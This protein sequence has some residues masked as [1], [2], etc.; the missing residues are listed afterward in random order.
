[1]PLQ[2]AASSKKSNKSK[3]Y[4]FVCPPPAIRS[5]VTHEQ[6][7]LHSCLTLQ[8]KLHLLHLQSAANSSNWG[9]RPCK[10]RPACVCVCVCVCVC[11]CVCHCS[12][13]EV[14]C[15]SSKRQ[16]TFKLPSF[17]KHTTQHSSFFASFQQITRIRH[18]EP[19]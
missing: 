6:M 4:T 12:A 15:F 14:F 5:Y 10:S 7:V 3:S 2:S 16:G 1:M 17:S 9:T 19:V 13:S 8:C 11:I 18:T